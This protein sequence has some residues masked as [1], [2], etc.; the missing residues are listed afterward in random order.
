[1]IFKLESH[2]YGVELIKQVH[3]KLWGEILDAL[4]AITDDELKR[5]LPSRKTLK[6]ISG[7][8]NY[9]IA[10]ELTKRGWAPQASIFNDTA[11]KQQRRWRLDFAKQDNGRPGV[12][13]EVA[14]NHA[15]AIAWNLIK[16]VLSSQLNHVEKDFQTDIGVIIM[17]TD[18]LKMSGGFDSAVGTF[19]QFKR[20]LV[21]LDNILAVPLVLI[22]LMPPLS[23]H[24]Q[25]EKVGNRMIGK[26]VDGLAEAPNV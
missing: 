3:P 15:E 5:E 18:A 9:L 12:A 10:R 16:P 22:G 11:Y 4:A 20:Y 8:I 19:E 14:F 23:F 1:M 21:P 26:M 13:I 25:L 24:I 6:S 17:A 7:P 2:H